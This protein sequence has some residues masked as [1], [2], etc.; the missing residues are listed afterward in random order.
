MRP[1]LT[2]RLGRVDRACH[3]REDEPSTVMNTVIL[4]TPRSWRERATRVCQRRCDIGGRRL[5]TAERRKLGIDP[6]LAALATLSRFHYIN[7]TA[8]LRC[9]VCETPTGNRR[10]LQARGWPATKDP[11]CR[12][13]GDSEQSALVCGDL[14]GLSLE[15]RAQRRMR[16]ISKPRSSRWVIDRLRGLIG[17]LVR[18]LEGLPTSR[19][20]GQV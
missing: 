10:R 6:P 4:D 12:F 9:A 15:P 1:A 16:Q 5:A 20:V 17:H 19:T 18:S 13:C 8:S 11:A 14:S 2:L 7:P 3:Y